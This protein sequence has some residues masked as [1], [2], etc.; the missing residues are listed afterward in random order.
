MIPVIRHV[1]EAFALRVDIIKR[2]EH[3]IAELPISSAFG[4]PLAYKR[5]FEGG[6]THARIAVVRDKDFIPPQSNSR[7][8]AQLSI[9]PSTSTE[10][11]N[12]SALGVE[13][14]NAMIPLIG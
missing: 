12:E 2:N 14:L 11:A 6:Y 3:R 4:T 9:S 1:E 10:C 7:R 5:A 13:D 8:F